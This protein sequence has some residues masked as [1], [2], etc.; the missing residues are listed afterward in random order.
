MGKFIIGLII[1]IL[2]VPCAFYV[3]CVSGHAPV[4]TS[5]A[6]MPFERFF[7]KTALHATLHRDAPKT[8]STRATEGELMAGAQVYKHH[9]AMCHGLPDKPPSDVAKGMFP[10]PPQLLKPGQMVTDD[11]A[12]VTYWKAKNGIRLTGMPGFRGSLT[13]AQLWNVSL[14][15]AN[16]DKL[17]PDVRNSLTNPGQMPASS[18]VQGS[19]AK[20]AA[21]DR[22]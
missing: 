22:K 15:L 12:G 3:Y 20:K 2:L 11:P 19:S 21:H 18:K 17:P 9:C 10:G 5:A 4:A 16:A 6:P 14:M 8:H 7:A 13:D 1:G